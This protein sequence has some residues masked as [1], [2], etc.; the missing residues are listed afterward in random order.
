M[1]VV[2]LPNLVLPSESPAA[3]TQRIYLAFIISEFRIG[4]PFELSQR[5]GRKLFNRGKGGD[6]SKDLRE[7]R[8]KGWLTAQKVEDTEGLCYSPGRKLTSNS[9]LHEEW[10]AFATSLF[11]NQGLVSKF[12]NSPVWGHGVFGFRQTLV[13]GA[14]V[15]RKQRFRR[16]DLVNYLQEFMSLSTIDSALKKMVEAKIVSYTD[17]FYIRSQSWE[18]N[19]KVFVDGHPGGK[20]R[21]V[22]IRHEV[23]IDRRIYSN[24]IREGKLTPIER[25]KLLKNPCVRCGRKSKEV[26]HFPPVKFGGKDHPH[27]VWAIC[28][29]CNAKTKAFI[30]K[31]DKFEVRPGKFHL[32]DS[33][34]DPNDMLR[35]SLS[36]GLGKFYRA[37]EKRDYA[38]GRRIVEKA[39]S[40]IQ[41]LEAD[42][43]LWK[44]RKTRKKRAPG[45]R[46]KK[47]KRPMVRESSRLKY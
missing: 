24:L 12:V 15:Y 3:A 14:L 42:A 17:G 13:L 11:G 30:R 37:A 20:A 7:L 8:A 47:G 18:E 46:V 2:K 22:R 6:F 29:S 45:T 10:L 44:R 27:L 41:A 5:S 31:I 36:D 39:C 43:L 28:H 25:K 21:Q 32:L 19:L 9:P 40:F 26:E 33:D 38:E 4:H 35:A 23:K 1:G 16:V 34:I